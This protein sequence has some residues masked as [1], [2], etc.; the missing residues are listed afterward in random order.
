M[1]DSVGSACDQKRAALSC[2]QACGRA[3]TAVAVE[4]FLLENGEEALSAQFIELRTEERSSDLHTAAYTLTYTLLHTLTYALLHPPIYT[5]PHT[6]SPTHC[7]THTYLRTAA[8]T[9]LR[10]AAHT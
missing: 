8:H 2:W 4:Q 1:C 9:H 5:L 3:Y 7:R 10:T 6:H